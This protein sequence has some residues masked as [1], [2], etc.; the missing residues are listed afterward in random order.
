MVNQQG[1][2]RKSLKLSAITL[3][4]DFSAKIVIKKEIRCLKNA[5]GVRKAPDWC[6]KNVIFGQF[7]GIL[8]EIL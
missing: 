3:C 6:Q 7:L 4:I 5:F 8:R 2:E 1:S